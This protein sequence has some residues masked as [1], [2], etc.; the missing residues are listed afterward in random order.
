MTFWENFSM[1]EKIFIFIAVPSTALLLIQFV[2]QLFGIGSDNDLGTDA[3]PDIGVDSS[4]EIG[5]M[6]GMST[7]STNAQGDF[8]T[9]DVG[10]TQ[11]GN[12]NPAEQSGMLSSFKT[13]RIFT[14][15]GFISFFA[16]SGWTG[17]LF[18]TMGIHFIISILLAFLCGVTAMILMA[19]LLKSLMGLQSD[20]T[21]DIK[22]AVG[23]IGEVY[24]R[25]PSIKKGKGKVTILIQGHYREFDA[26]T[27]EESQI[28]TGASVHV[29]GVIQN[30]VLIVEKV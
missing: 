20:G 2:L 17:L 16:I 21:I 5:G 7:D 26:I 22:N 10:D 29:V 30:E 9:E 4:T 13:L 19:L 6:D 15:Q 8:S 1:L 28:P 12:L 11:G 18:L 14:F 27:T 25:I 3:S 23:K 24:L